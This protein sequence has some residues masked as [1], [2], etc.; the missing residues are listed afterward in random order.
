MI[1]HHNFTIN[2]LL[3]AGLSFFDKHDTNSLLL[4]DLN[5]QQ[6][7]DL[8]IRAGLQT[9]VIPTLDE[10]LTHPQLQMCRWAL[11]IKSGASDAFAVLA[12]EV[13]NKLH[14]YKAIDRTVLISFDWHLLEHIRKLNSD[15]KL[16]FLTARDYAFDIEVSLERI[17]AARGTWWALHDSWAS[18]QFIDRVKR[19][20]LKIGFWTVNDLARA[21]DLLAWGADSLTTDHIDQFRT[22]K[23]APQEQVQAI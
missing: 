23:T 21:R 10:I 18:S 6:L 16:G 14:K 3:S 17:H 20:N 11:E 1:V 22:L 19:A 7:Q 12:E 4:R 8:K 9:G 15:I 5:L 2:P 13:V